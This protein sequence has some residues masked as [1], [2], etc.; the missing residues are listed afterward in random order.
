MGK[1]TTTKP[2]LILLYGLP[3][4]GKTFF[5]RQV[6]E[7]LSVAHVQGDRIRSELFEKPSYKKEENHIVASLMTYMTTEFLKAGVSVIFDT[8]A[9]RV[10]QRRSLRNLAQKT[11]AE[12]VLVWLQID[13]DSSYMRASKRD[14]RKHDDRYAQDM[15]AEVFKQMAAGMQHPD[16][17]ERH[18]V[19][20]GKHVFTTQRN[21]FFR[22]LRE[23]HLIVDPRAGEQVSKPGLIN[24]IPN[25]SAGRVD[26]NRRNV[27]IR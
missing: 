14:R 5:A 9:M 15:T 4:S 7:H 27:V 23:R 11:G 3:G 17:T 8:N 1:L 19:L 16:V 2:L 24:L 6:A 25:P 12:T 10:A 22:T 21:A 20:S 18:I 13:P 26:M